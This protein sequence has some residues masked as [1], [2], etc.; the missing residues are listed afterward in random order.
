MRCKGK[1]ESHL[2]VSSA[3]LTMQELPWQMES[4]NDLYMTC[5]EHAIIFKTPLTVFLVSS[6]QVVAIR[7]LYACYLLK[8]QNKSH[9]F[10]EIV[11]QCCC[12]TLCCA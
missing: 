4:H 11:R 3:L 1:A 8:H 6:L 2:H 7:L 12:L 9:L 5:V 10:S